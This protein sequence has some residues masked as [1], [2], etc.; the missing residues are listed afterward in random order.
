MYNVKFMKYFTKGILKGITYDTVVPW[1]NLDLATKYVAFL[2]D[3]VNTPVKAIG[4]DDYTCHVIRIEK[5]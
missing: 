4:G 5:E 2:L 1:V 3:H